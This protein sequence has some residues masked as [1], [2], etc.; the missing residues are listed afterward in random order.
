MPPPPN[1][2]LRVVIIADIKIIRRGNA[3]N[4]GEG[5]GCV[6]RQEGNGEDAGEGKED[7]TK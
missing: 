1:V 3:G 4:A 2:S 7:G 5:G 6:R